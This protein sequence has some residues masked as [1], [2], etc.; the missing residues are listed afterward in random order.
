MRVERINTN[1]KTI[2]DLGVELIEEVKN[3]KFFK[4]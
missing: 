1:P 4:N 3:K 2:I